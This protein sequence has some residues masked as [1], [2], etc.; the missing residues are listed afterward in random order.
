[1]LENVLEVR[2]AEKGRLGE[3]QGQNSKYNVFKSETDLLCKLSHATYISPAV[4][5]EFWSFLGK[6]K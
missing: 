6:I 4:K 2:V 5:N 1:M 3:F